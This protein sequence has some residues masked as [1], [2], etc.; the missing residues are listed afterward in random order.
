L[1]PLLKKLVAGK[2]TDRMGGRLK[3]AISGGAALAPEISKVFVSLGV[4]ILQGYGLTEAGPVVSVNHLDNNIP[5][6]IGI[7]LP[8]VEV[9]I[10]KD[11]ELL[12][13]G[14]NVMLGFW[15]NEQATAGIL[16]SDGWLHTGDKVRIE[17]EHLY[18]TG[19]IKDIIVLANGEKVAPT[20]MEIAVSGDPLFSQ[21]MIIGEARPYLTALV[22]LDGAQWNRLAQQQQLD[23][24]S[25]DGRQLEKI[26]LTRIADCLHEF[27]GYAQVRRVHRIREPWTVD[28]E[29]IT[30]T[31]KIKRK[32]I[33][34]RYR[35]EIEEMYEGHTV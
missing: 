22:V 30:P 35:K 3:V 27:P 16:D 4:P 33:L 10:G 17:G 12:V 19:R 5:A 6:S 24:D 11:E 7:P 26:L 14:P 34:E 31:L 32:Q 1:W 20:D 23:K 15:N 13:K 25:P 28:N 21:A 9:R 29:L 18:I 8:G 2:I